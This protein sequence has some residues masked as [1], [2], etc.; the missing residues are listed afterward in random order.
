M[1]AGLCGGGHDGNDIGAIWLSNINNIVDGNHAWTKL[2]QSA[3]IRIERRAPTGLSA[4]VA[5]G[6]KSIKRPSVHDGGFA[7]RRNVLHTSWKGPVKILQ[8][9]FLD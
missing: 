5:K 1:F 4:G 9:T 6:T 8:R 3:A 7:L 2:Q